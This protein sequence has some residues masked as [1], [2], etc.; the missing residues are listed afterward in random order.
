MKY[1][2]FFYFLQN[3][4][5]DPSALI[6]EDELT[7][8][9]NRRYLL[10]YFKNRVNWDALDDNPLCLLMIDGD[11]VKRINDQYG[12]N[13]GDQALVNIAGAIKAASPKNAVPVRYAGDNFLLLLP[14]STKAD[15]RAIA[16]KVLHLMRKNTFSA[17][18]AET[19]IPLTVSIGIAAAPEDAKN[20][21]TLIHRADTAMYQAK[22]SGRNR[23]ADAGD[24]GRAEIFPETLR[25]HLDTAGIAGRKK[26]LSK[27]STALKEVAEG[28]SRFIIV[29]GDP[30][31][32]KT[33]L[34][35]TIQENLQKTRLRP[36]RVNGTI[37]EAFRPYYLAS[38][39]AMG[40]L[41][42]LPDRGVK[43]LES[44]EEDE[45]SRLA[46]IIPQLKGGTP[47][48][49]ENNAGQR[50][51]I[52]A[53]FTRFLTRLAGTRPLVLLIDDFH[54]CDPA[55]LH[56]LRMLMKAEDLLIFICATA[57]REKHTSGESVALD[58]FRNAYSEELGIQT[59]NLT[60]L[61][62]ADIERHLNII[63]GGI[64]PPKGLCLEIAGI[65]QGNPMFL[66]EIIRKM[67]DD[68]KIYRSGEKWGITS[69]ENDYFPKSLDEIV[70][71][72]MECLDE[73]S[74][75]FL[76]RASALGE[77]TF[78]SMLAGITRDQGANI[79]DIINNAEEQ[80]IVR[81]E[82]E[83]NDE[84]L[85]FSSKQIR[86][87]IYD[88]ISPEEKKLL[89]QQIGAYQEKLYEQDLLPSAS[90]LAHHFTRST[91]A[92]TAKSY[93]EYQ[94]TQ[95]LRIFDEKEI[96]R[97]T[98][99]DLESSVPSDTGANVT[100]EGLGD[101]RLSRQGME[102]VPHLLRAL[103]IAIRN[104]RLYPEQSKSVT[105]AA[106]E[107]LKLL[108]RIFGTDAGISITG[109]QNRIL[110]N[111]EE[112]TETG[113]RGITDKILELWDKMEIRS[114]GFKKG[115][116]QT[117]LQTV[118]NQLALP[119][120]K[121]IPPG[122][123]ESFL[124]THQMSN[125]AIRQVTYTKISPGQDKDTP[126]P[127]TEPDEVK[128]TAG[129]CS[130]D[131][132]YVDENRLY[133]VRRV[134]STL[135]GA[136][137]QLKLYPSGGPV[138]KKAISRLAAELQECLFKNHALTISRVED[139]LL[140]NGVRVDAAGYGALFGGMVEMLANAGLN[141]LTF[142]RNLSET[143]LEIFFETL[144]HTPGEKLNS[145]FWEKFA[146]T[147]QFSGLFFD[148]RIYG[149]R[150]VN[151]LAADR[152]SAK[153]YDQSGGDKEKT[154][155]PEPGDQDLAG[156]IRD[157]F[158]KREI[159][160]LSTILYSITE[161]YTRSNQACRMD[162]IENFNKILHPQDWHPRA[163]YIK[164]VAARLMIPVFEAEKDKEKVRKISGILY[165]AAAKLILY[166][167]YPPAV[168][169]FTRLKKHPQFVETTGLETWDKPHAFGKQ[170]DP[171]IADILVS[172]LKATGQTRRQEACQLISTMGRGMT[173][174]LI[175]IIKQEQD[176]RTRR[177]GAEL[178]S[179]M[180]D[181]AVEQLRQ[182]LIR[183]S[184][185]EE[186]SRILEVI[187]S[188]TTDLATELKYTMTDAQ[189]QVRR[190][191]FR[192][193]RRLDTPEIDPLLIELARSTRADLAI[194]AI[195]TIGR[196][197]T[198]GAGNVLT[199]ILSKTKDQ[200]VLVEVCR[201]MERI[202]SS[203][204]IQPLA[205]ILMPKRRWCRR[206]RH[207]PSVRI[208]AAHAVCRIPGEHIQIM[209]QALK[210]DPNA[211]VRE[212]ASMIATRETAAKE[213]RGSRTT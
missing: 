58:L 189:E 144:F 133:R 127:E 107:V 101:K 63:F 148:R 65:T 168:R 117:E 166:G 96:K 7:G 173:P 135:M 213:N 88:G 157:L 137:G 38:Y 106:K 19:P 45:I 34:L 197:S 125:I 95:N 71:N 147:R 176:I 188:V 202:G 162:L 150:R 141:S 17:Q 155:T 116:D 87:I 44:M 39:A 90:F 26:Q 142:S 192:L 36:V 181:Q 203:D 193:A 110:I 94:E 209:M 25:R 191:A 170:L 47:T 6:F 61:D 48:I 196:R 76:D 104:T 204:F 195:N 134:I 67:I 100:I 51:A 81:T 118:L 50:E 60:P 37:Q 190:S 187:D 23:S 18:E 143:D 159:E 207:S 24:L 212:A 41:N 179:R 194:E 10:Y 146:R 138:A 74:R 115:T 9:Y 12:H 120:S 28:V 29:E 128:Q 55:S 75:K 40:L 62:E 164:L 136:Y 68:G 11:Y 124:R 210:R 22:H 56:L 52:F 13:A 154:K 201:A 73:K 165:E 31:M 177:L 152:K 200:D 64:D 85:R 66:V 206:R 112:L 156:L 54:Y 182:S 57:S 43:L 82:F 119:G 172:D 153:K 14:Q 59:I 32:G 184:R 4:G 174:M 49:P 27:V 33:S 140:V 111:G 80:G 2:K 83:E 3:V 77:S 98:G 16:E 109:E 158:L 21:K 35:A 122:Y 72:K 97:Y 121:T 151:P 145:G 79:Y 105:S 211:R 180:G 103:L 149:V 186:K 5:K 167:E 46:H 123:W 30:G 198:A 160:R 99:E 42:Q 205:K 114:L 130:E 163:A 92:Q 139:S 161:K 70:R 129:P 171:R 93:N 208:A 126:K 178:L 86:N 132:L 113:P 84:N 53:S 169:I 185:A 78:L 1:Q 199:E 91:D 89:H 20:E 131:A 69:P 183:E 15:T 8:L 102:L 108:E 175:D